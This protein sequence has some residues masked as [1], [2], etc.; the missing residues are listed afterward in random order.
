MPSCAG[1]HGHPRRPAGLQRA[2]D[3][4]KANGK[5]RINRAGNVYEGT[6]LELRVE[7]FEGLFSDAR[8]RFLAHGRRMAMPTRVDFADRYRAVVHNGTYTTCERVAANSWQP[9]WVLR[10]ATI[11]IDNREGW[12]RPKTRCWSSGHLGAAHSVHHLPAVGQAQVRPAAATVG[13][14]SR[15]GVTYHAAVLLEHRPQPRRHLARRADD[16]ARCQPGRR[17]PLPGAHLPGP[18][19]ADVMPT[20]RLRD[21]VRWSF[22]GKHQAID[23]C[24]WRAG[25]EPQL[26]RVSDDNYW[27]DFSRATEQLRQRLLPNDAT[28][29]WGGNDMS[30]TVRPSNGRRCRMSSPIVPPYDRMPQVQ[31]RYN[32]RSWAV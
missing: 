9:D 30:A 18:D 16:Q 31:W 3:L 21:R 1:R 15:D 32:R 11:R 19:R 25:A 5:V 8:Y 14:D 22:S 2:R 26:N 17:V 7:A 28:L 29:S 6:A 20:D 10:A 13:L 23:T 27:R 12:A 4:A 24:H